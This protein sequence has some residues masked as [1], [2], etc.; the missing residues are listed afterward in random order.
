MRRRTEEVV[1]DGEVRDSAGL[2]KVLDVDAFGLIRALCSGPTTTRVDADIVLNLVVHRQRPFTSERRIS[3]AGHVM[4][5]I[6]AVLSHRY[7]QEGGLGVLL[8]VCSAR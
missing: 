4:W 3:V 6:V 1:S 7:V 2:A 8:A 5:L